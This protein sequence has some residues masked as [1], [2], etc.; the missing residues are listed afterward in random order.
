MAEEL[1]A[2]IHILSDDPDG[3]NGVDQEKMQKS[4]AARRKI[5]EEIP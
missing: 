4:N 5:C 3:L 1:P 2:M